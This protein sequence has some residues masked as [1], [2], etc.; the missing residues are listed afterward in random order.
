M[1]IVQCEQIVDENIVQCDGLTNITQCDM[2]LTVQESETHS[3]IDRNHHEKNLR[4][5]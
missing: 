5:S 4:R 1:Y 3:L 2:M